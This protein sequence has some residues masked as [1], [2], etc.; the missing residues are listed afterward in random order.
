MPTVFPND[1]RPVQEPGGRLIRLQAHPAAGGQKTWMIFLHQKK[2]KL[3]ASTRFFTTPTVKKNPNWIQYFWFSS[4]NEC[5][6]SLLRFRQCFLYCFREK[7]GFS[8]FFNGFPIE[9]S[10]ILYRFGCFRTLNIISTRRPV[11]HAWFLSKNKVCS[12]K[13]VMEED[14]TFYILRFWLKCRKFDR[15]LHVLMSIRSQSFFSILA[16]I[17]IINKWFLFIWAQKQRW[18]GYTTLHKNDHLKTFYYKINRQYS[19]FFFDIFGRYR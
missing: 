4:E 15:I 5:Y 17:E 2:T 10:W 18:W 7:I 8:L 14:F 9:M 11:L 13:F 1:A 6:D 19:Y 16:G 12:K 3:Y